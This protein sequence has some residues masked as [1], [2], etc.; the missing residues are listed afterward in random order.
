MTTVTGANAKDLDHHGLAVIRKSKPGG[1]SYIA[2][3][4][5]PHKEHPFLNCT[6]TIFDQSGERILFRVDPAIGRAPKIE[7]L[8]EGSRVYFN[9]AD[10]FVDRVEI[11]CHL[12]QDEF[13]SHVFTIPRGQLGKVANL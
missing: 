4:V 5:R 8:P 7:G 10:E 11:R 1:K 13:T 12:N 9:V 6:V 3:I 2:L